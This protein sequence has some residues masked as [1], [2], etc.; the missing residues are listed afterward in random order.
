VRPSAGHVR[1]LA[2]TIALAIASPSNLPT[3]PVDREPSPVPVAAF[4]VKVEYG[5]SLLKSARPPMWHAAG[6][7]VSSDPS[8]EPDVGCEGWFPAPTPGM[9]TTRD[10]S[11]LVASRRGLLGNTPALTPC[12][13]G[14]AC[15]LRC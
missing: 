12:L 15:R 1:L 11:L 3:W 9:I 10:R 6:C 14:V 8:D 2:A 5:P 7:L 13:A 4:G